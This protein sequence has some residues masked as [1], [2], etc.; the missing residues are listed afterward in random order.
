MSLGIFSN[1]ANCEP[2]PDLPFEEMAENAFDDGILVVASVGN[3]SPGGTACN[4]ESPADLI[5]TLAVAG[6][7]S[8]YDSGFPVPTCA[9]NYRRCPLAQGG[10][11]RGGASALVNTTTH[12]NALSLVD[13]VAPTNVLLTTN[14]LGNNGKVDTVNEFNGSSAAAPHVSGAAALLKSQYLAAGKTWINSPGRLHSIMLAHAD[15]HFSTAPGDPDTI[16]TQKPKGADPAF[17]LGRLKMRLLAAGGQH[18]PRE[19]DFLARSFTSGSADHTY[20]PFTAPMPAGTTFVKCVMNTPEDMSGKLDI[21]DIDL[22]LRVAAPVFGICVPGSGA[23]LLTNA[24]TL[25]DTKSMVAFE[26]TNGTLAG[27]CLEVTLDKRFVTSAGVTAMT[28]CY[29][30]NTHD[31]V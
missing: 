18:N 15:R 27:A 16:T 10:A 22:K 3:H 4:M 11:S 1:S 20:L 9:S 21:S 17:G 28:Y 8:T 13:L 25:F 14:H 23:T 5:K 31:D 29:L 12:T 2:V 26:S 24:D 7:D 6:F 30:S 19:D